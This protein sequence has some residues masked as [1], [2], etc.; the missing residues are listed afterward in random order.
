MT[1]PLVLLYVLLFLLSVLLVLQGYQMFRTRKRALGRR[2]RW[3]RIKVPDEKMIICRIT[4]P[5]TV[6]SDVE[7]LVDDV[8]MAG[9]AFISG[10]KFEKII[11]KLLIKFPFTSFKEAGIVWGRIAY[12]NK[13]A[14]AEKY[15]VGVAYIRKTKWLKQ[16]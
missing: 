1:H 12:C 9:I 6:A 10:K 15:R 14:D 8:N 4:E 16:S 13:L 2:R 7:Y 5:A 11:I 3:G